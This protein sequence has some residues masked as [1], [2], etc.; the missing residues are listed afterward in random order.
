MPNP[1]QNTTK[2]ELLVYAYIRGNAVG[3]RIGIVM[4][5][6]SGYYGC[7]F[8]AP[9]EATPEEI[10][11]LVDDLNNRMGI[12]ADVAESA[13]MGSMFGWHVPAAA[14]AVA[15]YAQERANHV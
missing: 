7:D 11:A 3:K 12:P 15:F 2:L 9:A 4:F 8:D 10:K 13:F 6:E 1:K 14:R 5:H